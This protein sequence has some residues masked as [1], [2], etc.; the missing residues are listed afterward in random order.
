ME[1]KTLLQLSVG[2][3]LALLGIILALIILARKHKIDL[4]PLKWIFV[5]ALIS[6]G[7]ALIITAISSV[8]N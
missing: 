5:G 2:L 8:I 1:T 7:M 6:V 3:I 4:T